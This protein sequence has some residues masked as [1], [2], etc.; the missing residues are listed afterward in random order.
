[1]C[2]YNHDLIVSDDFTANYPTIKKLLVHEELNDLFRSYDLVARKYKKLMIIIGST[3]LAMGFIALL[4]IVLEL[5]IPA[6][7]SHLPNCAVVIIELLALLSIVFVVVDRI[8]IRSRPKYLFACFARERLRQW[9]FQLFVD[10]EFVQ[11]F[12]ADSSAGQKAL[13]SR[14]NSFKETLRAGSG[15]LDAFI[16]TPASPSRLLHQQ[17]KYTDNTIASNV[18]DALTTLRFEHQSQYP[19]RK[20]TSTSSENVLSLQEHYEWSETLARMSLLG[21]LLIPIVQLVLVLLKSVE[22]LDNTDTIHMTLSALVLGLVALSAASR[23]YRSGMTL[24]EEVESYE[25]YVA[26]VGTL[27]AILQESTISID[28]KQELLIDLELEAERELRRFLSMKRKATF[29]A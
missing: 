18:F 15:S 5:F 8:F 28:S 3:A 29:L 19:W 11:W 9:H 23:A 7:G 26:H 10:G 21:A 13:A 14:L 2:E 1:M 27:C 25:D 16:R 12:L 22:I 4:G 6:I 20:L 17:S 24:P